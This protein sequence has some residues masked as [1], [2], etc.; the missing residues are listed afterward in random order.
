MLMYRTK[1]FLRAKYFAEA[2]CYF[3]ET[4]LLACVND[5]LFCGS[6]SLRGKIY[7]NFQNEKLLNI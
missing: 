2:K 7:S 6:E 5:V 3:E 4:K 1:Y